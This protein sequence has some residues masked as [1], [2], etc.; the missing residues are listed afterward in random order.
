MG[1][2]AKAIRRHRLIPWLVLFLLVP[3]GAIAL[4]GSPV[5]KAWLDRMAI[6]PDAV[7]F[8]PGITA[9]TVAPRGRGLVITSIRSDSQAA[10]SGVVVGDVIVAID[11]VHGL[12]LD[13][14]RDYLMHDTTDEV[15]LQIVHNRRVRDIWL[16]RDGDSA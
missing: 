8:L 3:V 6:H 1:I 15:R 10:E 5:G 16:S 9:E 13:Q 14:A 11:N 12:S 4:V 7:K 2:I